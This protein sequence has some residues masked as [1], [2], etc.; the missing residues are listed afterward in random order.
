[1]TATLHRLPIAGQMTGDQM[2]ALRNMDASIMAA[3][4]A[5]IDAG[6]PLGLVVAIL[7][8][9]AHQHTASMVR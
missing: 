1:M 6:V 7:H 9:H 3:V 5:T 4:A 8:A 2:A